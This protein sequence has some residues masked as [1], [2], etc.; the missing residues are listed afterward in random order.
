MELFGRFSGSEGVTILEL[1]CFIWLDR[2]LIVCSRLLMVV[3][4]VSA[5]S[6]SFAIRDF[7]SPFSLFNFSLDS[8]ILCRVS[9]IWELKL[10]VIAGYFTK[11]GLRIS[12]ANFRVILS[13]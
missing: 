11:V 9:S 10:S 4:E 6:S 2:F 13:S 1:E 7:R 3:V 5:F 8:K 12:D